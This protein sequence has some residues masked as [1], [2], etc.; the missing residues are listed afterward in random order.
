MPITQPPVPVPSSEEH[1]VPTQ[2]RNYDEVQDLQ[3]RLTVLERRS[4]SG[5][6]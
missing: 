1:G 6:S 5:Q 3:R 4:S 2:Q